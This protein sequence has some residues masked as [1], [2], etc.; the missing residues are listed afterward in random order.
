MPLRDRS[1]RC[2]S[3]S[4]QRRRRLALRQPIRCRRPRNG[5][6]GERRGPGSVPLG[7]AKALFVEGDVGGFGQYTPLAEPVFQPDDTLTVYAQ[8]LDTGSSKAMRDMA[9]ASSPTTSC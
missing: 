9:S 1:A 8:P 6:R 4:R 5:T 3:A 7:F 2:C